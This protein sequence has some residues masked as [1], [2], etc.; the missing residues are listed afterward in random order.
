MMA[1]N[2]TMLQR[3]NALSDVQLS[4]FNNA[5]TRKD[6]AVPDEICRQHKEHIQNV[7]TLLDKKDI[8]YDNEIYNKVV[9][10]QTDLYEFLKNTLSN[11]FNKK[12]FDITYEEFVNETF[13]ILKITYSKPKKPN[14]KATYFNVMRLHLNNYKKRFIA[15]LTNLETLW[16]LQNKEDREN[17]TN[18]DIMINLAFNIEQSNPKGLTSINAI[19]FIES[20]FKICFDI[21]YNDLMK[22]YFT[23]L[24][25]G[26][27]KSNPLFTIPDEL[28]IKTYTIPKKDADDDKEAD[29][30]NY[31][32]AK[33]L[34][35]YADNYLQ[36]L[37]IDADTNKSVVYNNDEDVNFH[38]IKSAIPKKSMVSIYLDFTSAYLSLLNNKIYISN[39]MYQIY[40][41]RNM[42]EL[43]NPN[44][45]EY[46]D[47]IRKEMGLMP[48]HDLEMNDAKTENGNCNDNDNMND[49]FYQNDDEEN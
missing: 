32:A 1:Q 49:N 35:N 6:H 2:Q 11:E 24:K 46:L 34:G 28:L 31:Y 10:N 14:Q 42:K 30:I 23:T 37:I 36:T 12:K 33:F 38:N 20:S 39:K 17:K 25:L 18:K 9:D 27:K 40:V 43:T 45:N 26:P 48:L 4:I 7:K 47:D 13:P 29:E 21:F 41:K 5:K 22:D 8:T 3:F 19:K 15:L 44:D 16:N